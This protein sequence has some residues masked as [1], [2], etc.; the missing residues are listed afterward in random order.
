MSWWKRLMDWWA[1]EPEPPELVME[2]MFEE[3]DQEKEELLQTDPTPKELLI[4][5]LLDDKLRQGP[6]E[7][8]LMASFMSSYW[9]D[10]LQS[11]FV[12]RIDDKW[13]QRTIRILNSFEEHE[14]CER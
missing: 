5:T 7:R 2:P 8:R 6:R 10:R 13:I 1:D 9:R 4:D 3:E 11:R 14:P 12:A